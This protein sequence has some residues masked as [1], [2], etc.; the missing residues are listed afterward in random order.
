MIKRTLDLNTYKYSLFLFGPRL[1]GKTYLIKNT[2][3]PDMYINLL[4][5]DERSRYKLKP[6]LFTQEVMELKKETA[7]VVIDEIQYCPE[8]LDEIH[9]LIEEKKGIKFIMTGSS[10]RKLRKAGVNLLGGRAMTL[11]LHPLTHEELKEDFKLDDAMRFGTLPNIVL[12][13][14]TTGKSRLLKA[15]VKT[16]LEQEI[17]EEAITR[18]IPVFERF[19]ELASFENGNVLNYQNIS[20]ECAISSK[21]VKEYF[22]MLDDTLMGFFLLPYLKSHRERLTSHPKFYFFDCGVVT[23]LRKDLSSELISGTPPFGNAFEH[24]VIVEMKRILDYREREYS[25][26]YFRTADGAEVDVI[27]EFGKD[28]WAI[29]IKSAVAPQSKDAKGLRSFTGDHEYKRAIC[30]CQ[31]PRAYSVNN[32]EFLPWREFF[33]QI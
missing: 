27:L 19:L 1:V 10:A 20:R 23:A 14:G 2:T 7:L 29:E 5:S 13:D 24:W 18:N 11:N 6:S 31:T 33:M 22:H 8:L 25:L 4:N 3:F 21:T 9:S 15:Y 17:K 26:S 30:V 32:I 28:V 12:E 16:Y